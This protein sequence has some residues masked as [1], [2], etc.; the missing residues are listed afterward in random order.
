MSDVY[1]TLADLAKR[2]KYGGGIDSVIEML[3]ETNPILDDAPVVEGNL[4]T[5]HR[6]TQRAT[7]PTG[8]W[9]QINQGV[10]TE[11]STTIQVDDT[12]G[13][14]E[15]YSAIDDELVRLSGDK[16]KFR[17][18]EDDAFIA[19]LSNSASDAIFYASSLTD[20]EKM[21]GLAPRYASTTGSTAN[22][23]ITGGGSG[24]DN[25]SVWIIKWSPLTCHLIYPK[26][27][28]AGIESEDLGKIPWLDSSNKHYQAWVTHY[29][30]HL[31]LALRD[32]R[33]VARVCN[34]DLSD[35]TADASSGADLLDKMIDA[36]YTIPTADLGKMAKTFVYCNKTVAKFLHKQAMNKSNVNLTLETV[37]GKR[38]THFLEAPVHICD[39]ITSAET[40]VS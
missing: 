2:R 5:G 18:S 39:S 38:V 31:G 14:L 36:Y 37:A 4:P 32:Y 17:A 1:M 40:L 13:V 7:L 35:L 30:W 28:K 23:I 27:T 11:K 10:D 19:G 8:T 26:G 22:Y 29:T 20:P 9:R 15:G 33:Y 16:G 3:A 25:T 34:I 21:H 6:S 12:C 24:S